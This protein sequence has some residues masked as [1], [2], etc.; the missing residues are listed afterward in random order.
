[1]GQEVFRNAPALHRLSGFPGAPPSLAGCSVSFAGLC[2]NRSLPAAAPVPRRRFPSVQSLKKEIEKCRPRAVCT[3]SP[4]HRD[5]S[6]KSSSGRCGDCRKPAGAPKRGC[7]ELRP[8]S[9]HCASC[10]QAVQ[11][12]DCLTYSCLG[13]MQRACDTNLRAVSLPESLYSR[14]LE[15]S[16]LSLCQRGYLRSDRCTKTCRHHSG[17]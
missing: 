4:S 15:V 1:V 16:L 8:R 9:H 14:S 10:N 13:R 11:V 6:T 2:S 3:K 5:P 7:N 17:K 12:P